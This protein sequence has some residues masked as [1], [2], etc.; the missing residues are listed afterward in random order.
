L[1]SLIYL[2]RDADFDVA[3]IAEWRAGIRRGEV[4]DSGLRRAQQP[5]RPIPIAA[6]SAKPP[7]RIRDAPGTV[8]VDQPLDRAGEP[9]GAP[10]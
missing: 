10:L 5:C 2:I 8:W 9:G 3:L 6:T 1:S 4:R 7:D